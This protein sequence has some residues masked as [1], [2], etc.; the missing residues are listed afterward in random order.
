MKSSDTFSPTRWHCSYVVVLYYLFNWLNGDWLFCSTGLVG[1]R[2]SCKIWSSSEL[3]NKA[4]SYSRFLSIRVGDLTN[5]YCGDSFTKLRQ[6]LWLLWISV[7]NNLNLLALTTCAVHPLESWDIMQS[8]LIHFL[9]C[10]VFT[11]LYCGVSTWKLS[12]YLTIN[13]FTTGF[14]IMPLFFLLY[15]SYIP[16]NQC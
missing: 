16:M 6:T 11:H 9:S 1:A 15:C 10:V 5:Y 7:F 12:W 3:W 8:M 2:C 4:Q 13:Q 14:L